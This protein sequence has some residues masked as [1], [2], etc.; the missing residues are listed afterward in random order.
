MQRYR[1]F[2]EVTVDGRPVASAF[3]SR[4]N[5]ATITDAPGIEGDTVDLTFDDAG[6]EIVIP[7]EGARLDV[8]FGFRDGG[9]WRMGSF[10]I[11]KPK[12][13]GGDEGEFVSLSGRSV[14]QRSDIKEPLSEHF[15]DATIGQIVAELADRHGLEAKVGEALSNISLPYIA[16][17]NQSSMDFLTRLAER[18]GALFSIKAG[19]LLFLERGKQAALTIDKSDC[20]GWSFTIDPRPRHGSTEA[21]WFDRASGETRFETHATGLEGP[22]KRLRYAMPTREQAAAAAKSEGDAL[23]RRTGDGSIDLAGKPEA[24]ADMPINLTGF[25]PEVNGE[26][27]AGTV[28]HEFGDAYTTSIELVAPEQGKHL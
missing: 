13:T 2:L 4:L 20:S 21:G 12:I 17:T 18:H 19:K 8:S 11:D 23:G 10:V 15:D 1:P 14:D 16:R 6:N 9:M 27:R 5:K 7:G 26:W 28:T 3:Y 25:R 22:V 24:M